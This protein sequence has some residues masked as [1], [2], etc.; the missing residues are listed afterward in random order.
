MRMSRSVWS[1]LCSA[2][3]P[4]TAIALALLAVHGWILG[5]AAPI[6]ETTAPFLFRVHLLVLGVFALLA[7]W[8]AFPLWLV[9]CLCPAYRLPAS[10]LIVQG[11]VFALGWAAIFGAMAFVESS[12]ARHAF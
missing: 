6:D 9:L 3:S 5:D 1:W 11:V 8:A 12:P 4:L 10:T 2:S 7:T